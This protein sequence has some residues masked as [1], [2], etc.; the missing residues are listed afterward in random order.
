MFKVGVLRRMFG[1]ERETERTNGKKYIMRGE[2]FG[3]GSGDFDVCCL[4]GCDV[5]E[6]G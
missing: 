5:V 3:S 6:F 4:V 1:T 2:I